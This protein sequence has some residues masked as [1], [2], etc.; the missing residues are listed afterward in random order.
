MTVRT[1]IHTPATRARLDHAMVHAAPH[2]RPIVGAVRDHDV[3]MMFV[4]QAAGS[5]RP[6][7]GR[8]RPVIFMIG[9][10]FDEAIRTRVATPTAARQHG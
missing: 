5:F 4:S 9:D 10:D 3:D 8:R 2:L 6:Q 7:A 1:L